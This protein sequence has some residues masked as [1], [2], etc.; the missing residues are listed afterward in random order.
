MIAHPNP[1]AWVW[2]AAMIVWGPGFTSGQ[3]SHH[4]IQLVMVTHGTLRIRSKPGI[5]WKTCGAALIRPDADHEVDA[6]GKTILVGFFDPESEL[7]A[8]FAQRIKGDISRLATTDVERWRLALG[9]N[10]SQ[11]RVERWVRKD[12]LSGRGAVKIHPRVRRVLKYLRENLGSGADV[13]LKSLADVSGLSPSR[14]MH[15]FTASVGVPVRPYILWLRLQRASYELM[16]GVT[17]TETAHIAGFSDAAHLTRT[18]RRMLGTTPKD[19]AGRKTVSKGV[20]I[21]RRETAATNR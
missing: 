12:L 14:L 7:G 8:A 16:N 17:V 2:P 11:E 1:G 19:L 20:S 4:C 10:L 13:S 18:F 21:E 5:A 6:R 9:S 15:V 3:H